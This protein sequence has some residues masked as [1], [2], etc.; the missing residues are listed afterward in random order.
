MTVDCHTAFGFLHPNDITPARV[1]AVVESDLY[2]LRKKKLLAL[3]DDF[4]E[5]DMEKCKKSGV[6]NVKLA[7]AIRATVAEGGAGNF[8]EHGESKMGNAHP[9][10]RFGK[11]A[12]LKQAVDTLTLP[13][14]AGS[15]A[16]LKDPKSGGGVSA[17]IPA[18]KPIP[19]EPT[20]IAPLV[21]PPPGTTDATHEMHVQT[22]SM[23]LQQALLLS[24]MTRFV[25]GMS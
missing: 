21:Q 5:F 11:F 24:D 25:D 10:K 14:S 23:L 17:L 18:V 2:V 1:V 19:V 12:S 13:G 6:F 7:N 3:Y 16:V 8:D 20:L 15:M 9:P 4:P 22:Q